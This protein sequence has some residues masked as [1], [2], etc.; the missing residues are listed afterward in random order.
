MAC[1]PSPTAFVI[2]DAL[3]ADGET[4]GAEKVA[5]EYRRLTGIIDYLTE[6]AA[7]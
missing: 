4:V 5:R 2:A 6:R 3:N 1:V 7:R